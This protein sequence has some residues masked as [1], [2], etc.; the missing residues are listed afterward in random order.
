[1]PSL[2]PSQPVH[3]ALLAA[4]FVLATVLAAAYFFYEHESREEQ[5]GI[6]SELARVNARSEIEQ[7]AKDYNGQTEAALATSFCLKAAELEALV[8]NAMRTGASVP[9]I[10]ESLALQCNGLQ[11]F[12]GR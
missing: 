7:F 9:A 3:P 2:S 8:V 11:A 1:M 12:D 10:L 4:W 5:A 6:L